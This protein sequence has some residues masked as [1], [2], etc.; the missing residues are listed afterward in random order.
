MLV[1]TVCVSTLC[2]RFLI[3]GD[4]LALMALQWFPPSALVEL[5]IWALDNRFSFNWKDET[6]TLEMLFFSFLSII[7]VMNSSVF[8][9]RSL[10]AVAI[11]SNFSS[12]RRIG[13]QLPP[14][15]TSVMPGRQPGCQRAALPPP[16]PHP[17]PPTHSYA[18]RLNMLL[19]E[20]SFAAGGLR[21][22]SACLGT[23]QVQPWRA[24]PAA[25]ACPKEVGLHF[26]STYLQA[27]EDYTWVSLAWKTLLG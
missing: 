17:P 20:Q 3:E 24:S 5:F 27:W 22:L 4:P 23:P 26:S 13:K 14:V 6:G 16:L 18:H 11:C 7:S 21:Y 2:G 19:F 25:W 10:L 15:P 1:C 12:A 9:V 8:A